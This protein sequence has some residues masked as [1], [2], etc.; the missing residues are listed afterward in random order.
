L[1]HGV[2]TVGYG[3]DAKKGIPFWKVKNS[4]GPTWG[5]QGY[6]FIK[7]IPNDTGK[8]T[9]GIQMDAVYATG[10]AK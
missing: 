5:N 10:V 1:D 3:I 9:C 2:L 4:W 6:I 7:R 8:G